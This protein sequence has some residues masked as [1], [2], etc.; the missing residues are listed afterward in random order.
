MAFLV[1]HVD[2]ELASALRHGPIRVSAIALHE[3]ARAVDRVL[4]LAHLSSEASHVRKLRILEVHLTVGAVE[5]LRQRAYG[6]ERVSAHSADTSR[7]TRL[8][9][10]KSLSVERAKL[11]LVL[12][13]EVV[14]AVLQHASLRTHIEASHAFSFGLS[15]FVGVLHLFVACLHV[16]GADRFH[17]GVQRARQNVLHVFDVHAG[18]R[19]TLRLW[20]LVMAS[21][22]TARVARRDMAT[23]TGREA[24][25]VVL[26]ACA[27][28][29]SS[30]LT[31]VV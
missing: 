2:L 30:R 16:A 3:I 15:V 31:I 25:H 19:A 29:A 7:V 18:A 14:V 20:R 8:L 13:D 10:Y 22:D 21:T 17:L 23:L 5:V 12:L 27:R 6:A 9:V 11:R 28:L 26:V 24:A 1:A 4:V